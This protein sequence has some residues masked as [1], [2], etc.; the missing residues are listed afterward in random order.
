LLI[1]NHTCCLV[2]SIPG[3]VYSSCIVKCAGGFLFVA[4]KL[5]SSCHHTSCDSCC[6]DQWSDTW[7]A[8]WKPLL[9]QPGCTS[10][11]P[12]GTLK[13]FIV[14]TDHPNTE[15]LVL[16]ASYL[17]LFWHVLVPLDHHLGSHTSFTRSNTVY[18]NLL[19]VIML[20]WKYLVLK[21]SKI[22]LTWYT[23]S[24]FTLF[25]SPDTK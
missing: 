9:Q 15:V 1:W 19:T 6:C 18:C 12:L 13:C 2:H 8:V 4:P 21:P 11:C 24:I 10:P 5:L 20:W 23:Y 14:T 22:V 16:V 17:L 7:D 25:L 3:V